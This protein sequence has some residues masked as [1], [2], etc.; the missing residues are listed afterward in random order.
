MAGGAGESQRGTDD[1]EAREDD[2]PAPLVSDTDCEKGD[3][4]GTL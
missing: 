2:S 4:G 1:C 3:G